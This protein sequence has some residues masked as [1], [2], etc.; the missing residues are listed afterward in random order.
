MKGRLKPISDDNGKVLHGQP[1]GGSFA[2]LSRVDMAA[3]AHAMQDAQSAVLFC[4]A[5]HAV[6][7]ERMRRGELAGCKLAR[8]SASRLAEITGRPIRTIRHALMRLK[9]KGTIVAE[10]SGPGKTSV[11]RLPLL[12]GHLATA[13]DLLANV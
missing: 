8:V 1:V 9:K 2:L 3:I 7:Q 12:T 4:L 13:S 6:L 11:Y 10:V 5:W